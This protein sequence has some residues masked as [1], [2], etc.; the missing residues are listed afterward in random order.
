M[1]RILILFPVSI[2]LSCSGQDRSNG[3]NG[4]VDSL[5]IAYNNLG[6][7]FLARSS[8]MGEN[9]SLLLDSAIYFF[10][11]GL[12]LDKNF[13]TLYINKSQVLRKKLKFKEAIQIL[14]IVLTINPKYP[15]ILMGKGFLFE[16]LNNKEEA[17]KNYLKAK[18]I[19]LEQYKSNPSN[20]TVKFNSIF[21]L[22]FIEGKEKALKEID[23]LSTEYPDN[24]EI[25]QFRELIE[26]FD[27]SE[28]IN[29]Y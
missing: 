17:T 28:F 11:K 24:I 18:E 7:K 9:S 5:A 15:E 1:L 20:I 27:K 13:S 14:D 8:Q 6:V 21:S 2:I 4:V 19:F 26:S 12:E 25:T 3:K 16:K 10:D 22:L 23:K 29:D